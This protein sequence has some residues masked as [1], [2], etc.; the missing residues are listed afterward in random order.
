MGFKIQ[1]TDCGATQDLK[2]SKDGF[3]EAV[4]VEIQSVQN[5]VIQITCLVCDEELSE[6]Y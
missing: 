5:G 6:D 2:I 3:L 1:C 4:N